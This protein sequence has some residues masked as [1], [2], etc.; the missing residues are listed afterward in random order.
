ME[1][2]ERSKLSFFCAQAGF[3]QTIVPRRLN[4][5]TNINNITGEG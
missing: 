2:S 4:S 5:N 1:N 3:S